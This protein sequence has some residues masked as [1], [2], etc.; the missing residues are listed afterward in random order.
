M[1]NNKTLNTPTPP[2]SNRQTNRHVGQSLER[3]EDSALLSGRGRFIDDVGVKP[4]TL[5]AAILRSPHAH[6]RLL[7]INC[8]SATQLPGVR[9]IITRDDVKR[10][11]APFVVGVKSP[12]ECWSLAIE[13][14][15][16]V[17]EPVAVVVAESRYIA[18][19]ALDLIDVEY[20]ALSAVV[21]FVRASE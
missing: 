19:D 9:A 8:E 3:F 4:G 2:T 13:K 7:A 16:Y 6:A 20:H 1:T 21:V 14:V 17:G 10:W 12:M 5:Y 11:S 15:R 18:E